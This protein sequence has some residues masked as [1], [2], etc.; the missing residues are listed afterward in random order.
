MESIDE[1]FWQEYDVWGSGIFLEENTYN[2]ICDALAS[3]VSNMFRELF[4]E[5]DAYNLQ[6]IDG[7]DMDYAFK[8]A[9]EFDSKI[10]N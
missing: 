1:L 2:S 3:E 4:G 6:D 7:F 9:A 10:Y 8:Q 5:D